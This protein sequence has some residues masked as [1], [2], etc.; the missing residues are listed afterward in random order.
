MLTVDTERNVEVPTTQDL[1]SLDLGWD[2]NLPEEMKLEQSR[3]AYNNKCKTVSEVEETVQKG[4]SRLRSK[5]AEMSPRWN[6]KMF[7]RWS[8]VRFLMRFAGMGLRRAA[9]MSPGRFVTK[10]QEMSPP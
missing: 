3:A 4:V 2:N 6:A 5:S 7:L 8:G 10:Y 9:M 1:C